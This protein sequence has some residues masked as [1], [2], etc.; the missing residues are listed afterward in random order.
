M[1]DLIKKI[2]NAGF[3]IEKKTHLGFIIFPFFIIIKFFNKLIRIN[4]I[5]TKQ[6]NF[7]NNIFVKT[8][9]K[10]DQKPS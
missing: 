6:A 8:L 3:K 9:F 7:S 10:I 2:T 4:N 1:N 5:V